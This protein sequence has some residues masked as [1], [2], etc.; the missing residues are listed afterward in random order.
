MHLER[1]LEEPKVSVLSD[2]PSGEGHRRA[3]L[4]VSGIVCRSVCVTRPTVALRS[5]PEVRSVTFDEDR[6]VFVVEYEADAPRA[7]Q[8]ER[9]ILGTVVGRGVRR[10]LEGVGRALGRRRPTS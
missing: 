6:D 3:Q 8:F 10:W 1:L 5:L 7:A 4:R 9:A 2:E